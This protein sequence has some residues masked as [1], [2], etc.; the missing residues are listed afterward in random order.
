MAEKKKVGFLKS[1]IQE[2]KLVTWPKKKQLRKDT[3]VVLE[4]SILFAIFFGIV[5]F[6]L[7]HALQ[8]ILK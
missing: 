8:L 2:M 5:D 7:V 6:I 1:V 4:T 3:I